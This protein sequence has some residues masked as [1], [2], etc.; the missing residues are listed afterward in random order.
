MSTPPAQIPQPPSHHS[1]L[2][3]RAFASLFPSVPSWVV[4]AFTGAPADPACLSAMAEA[5]HDGDWAEGLPGGARW[6]RLPTT[7]RHG[8]TWRTRSMPTW[9][10]ATSI[11][12]F[13]LAP[14]AGY[15]E[16]AL[17]LRARGWARDLPFGVPSATLH[18]TGGAAAWIVRPNGANNSLFP[19]GTKGGG[20]CRADLLARW[21]RLVDPEEQRALAAFWVGHGI[22]ELAALGLEAL[23]L[24]AVAGVSPTPPMPSGRP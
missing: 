2:L 12:T 9:H 20:A 5:S 4:A 8:S 11:W 19:I 3:V 1:P 7:F 18:L 10:T 17:N 16:W 13:E 14:V 22:P 21:Q 6:I 24:E 23:R 15:R